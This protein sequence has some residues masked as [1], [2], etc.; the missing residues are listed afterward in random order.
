MMMAVKEQR[1]MIKR[2]RKIEVFERERMGDDPFADR[3]KRLRNNYLILFPAA[4][5]GI[6]TFSVMFIN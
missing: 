2:L 4:S 1:H 5:I 3:I 6:F